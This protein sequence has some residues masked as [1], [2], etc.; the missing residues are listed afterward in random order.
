MDT[1]KEL[2]CQIQ[3][4]T[5]LIARLEASYPDVVI[6]SREWFI[7]HTKV[8]DA[9]WRRRMLLDQLEGRSSEETA[10]VY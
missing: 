8:R 4:E 7:H 1:K 5:D 6:G 2:K 3:E 9:Y 10:K